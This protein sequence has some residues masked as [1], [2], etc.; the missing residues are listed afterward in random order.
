[1]LLIN[2]TSKKENATRKMK[3]AILNTCLLVPDFEKIVDLSFIRPCQR[4]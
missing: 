2:D 4:T 3:V 1:M